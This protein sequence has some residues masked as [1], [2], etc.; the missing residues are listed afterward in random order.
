[1]ISA[2]PL[3]ELV[4]YEPRHGRSVR[5]PCAWP[6]CTRLRNAHG[7]CDPHRLRVQRGAE[8]GVETPW[9][10]LVVVALR[11]ADAETDR[12]WDA[13]ALQLDKAARQ[14]RR[15]RGQLARRSP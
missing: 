6:G 12:E 14:Y 13:A 15:T 1:V 8:P 4:T 2:I 3:A 7:L 11:L 10:Q 9:E 5:E